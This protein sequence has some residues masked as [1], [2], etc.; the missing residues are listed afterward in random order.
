MSKKVTTDI[1]S[2]MYEKL[3]EKIPFGYQS[4]LI[5]AM[6]ADFLRITENMSRRDSDSLV[7]RMVSGDTHF[8]PVSA[9]EMATF[10]KEQK[11]GA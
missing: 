3:K 5:E 10:L 8:I 9:D 2:G 6:L 7:L 1:Q 4:S 11:S